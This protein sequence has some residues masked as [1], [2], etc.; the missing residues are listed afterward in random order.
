M[1]RAR[2][3]ED[4]GAHPLV[5]SCWENRS[6]LLLQSTAPSL[7][8]WLTASH[9][10]GGGSNFL[11]VASLNGSTL[12]LTSFSKRGRPQHSAEFQTLRKTRRPN[13]DGAFAS[14]IMAVSADRLPCRQQLFA[15]WIGRMAG[16]IHSP[17]P[18]AGRGPRLPTQR[19]RPSGRHDVHRP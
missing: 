16:V 17:P 19:A 2:S 5:V 15:A 4:L 12:S 7:R 18:A 1:T 11:Y 9:A 3:V 10:Y 6:R 14:N 8:N 13:G